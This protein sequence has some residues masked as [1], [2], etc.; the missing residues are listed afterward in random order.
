VGGGRLVAERLTPAGRQHHEGVAA[1][2][3]AGDRVFLQR[4][5]AIVAPDAPDRLVEEL[6]LD[7]G[8]MI[9]ERA[10]PA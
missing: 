9:A 7:D 5:K 4:E 6:S 1:L 2:E 10:L 8:A 3:H